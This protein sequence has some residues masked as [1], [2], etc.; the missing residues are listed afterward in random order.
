M[1]NGAIFAVFNSNLSD[2]RYSTTMEGGSQAF[3][4]DFDSKGRPVIGGSAALATF[5]LTGRPIDDTIES[6]EGIVAK[7]DVDNIGIKAS[8]RQMVGGLGTAKGTVVLAAPAPAGGVVV[9]LLSNTSRL[10]VPVSVTVPQGSKTA[11]FDIRSHSVATT[12]G[13]MVAAH[14]GGLDQHL[15]FQMKPGGLTSLTLV[16]D[17][18]SGGRSTTGKVTLSAPA[19]ASGNGAPAAGTGLV[20]KLSSSLALRPSP[21]ERHRPRGLD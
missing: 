9:P 17:T 11:T 12:Q 18:V 15:Y 21:G 2:L 14:V 20:V 16:K 6:F 4:I 1:A 19:P 13:G 8:P 10:E 5:P 3:A 7:F